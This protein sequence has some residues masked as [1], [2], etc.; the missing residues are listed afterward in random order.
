M[1]SIIA[2]TL[3]LNAYCDLNLL[4]F[5]SYYILFVYFKDRNFVF[6]YARKL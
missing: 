6:S 1:M 4:R 2:F 5:M 3:N